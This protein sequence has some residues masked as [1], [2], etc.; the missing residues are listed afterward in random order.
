[1][2]EAMLNKDAI[3][4]GVTQAIP[5]SS[6]AHRL[7]SELGSWMPNVSN[8]NA[9]TFPRSVKQCESLEWFKFAFKR[10]TRRAPQQLEAAFRHL[11]QPEGLSTVSDVSRWTVC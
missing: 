1:M 8:T 6:T 4:D 5:Y 2:S 11:N 7:N 9:L 3:A 10:I